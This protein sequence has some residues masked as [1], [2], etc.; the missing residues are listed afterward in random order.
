MVLLREGDALRVRV[1]SVVQN[2]LDIHSGD[3]LQA[4]ADGLQSEH[5]GVDAGAIRPN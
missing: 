2:P 5:F 4:A 3:F 1:A